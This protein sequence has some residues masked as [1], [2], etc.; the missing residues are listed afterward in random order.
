MKKVLSVKLVEAEICCSLSLQIIVSFIFLIFELFARR[1]FDPI[2]LK[3]V[4][5]SVNLKQLF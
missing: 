4:Y 2:S 1:N 5:I 3:H